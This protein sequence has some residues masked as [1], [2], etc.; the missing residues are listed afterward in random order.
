M[1]MD[2][3]IGVKRHKIAKK[4]TSNVATHPTPAVD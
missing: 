1:K 4:S 3:D 2:K